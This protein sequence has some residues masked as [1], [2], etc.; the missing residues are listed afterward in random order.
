MNVSHNDGHL[1]RNTATCIR[2]AVPCRYRQHRIIATSESKSE[3]THEE[4]W[5]LLVVAA[6]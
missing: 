2:A 5:E 4:A 1:Y 3:C 6:L